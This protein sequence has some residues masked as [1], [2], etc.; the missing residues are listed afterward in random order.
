MKTGVHF[1]RDAFDRY[2][3]VMDEQRIGFVRKYFP[4]SRIRRGRASVVPRWNAVDTY[5]QKS[6]DFV[7]RKDAAL[8]L[9]KLARV[10]EG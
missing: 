1:Q 8:W 3:V 10:D 4:D 5:M 6:R 2:L 9:M 7:S